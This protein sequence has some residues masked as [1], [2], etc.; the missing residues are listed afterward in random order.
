MKIFMVNNIYIISRNGKQI[1]LIL[2]P[3]TLKIFNRL[4]QDI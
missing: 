2:F 3:P 1:V 4:R